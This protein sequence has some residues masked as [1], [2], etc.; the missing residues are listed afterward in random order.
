MSKFDDFVENVGIGTIVA[1][2][3]GI[4]VFL[5]PILMVG[6]GWVAGWI[7]RLIFGGYITNGLNLLLG[8]ARF[9]ADHL[10]MICA[11]L[12]VVGSFFKTTAGSGSSNK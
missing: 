9:E 10:P 5:S 1:G 2:V 3:V 8:T 4:V 7:I 6:F 12:G 11:T